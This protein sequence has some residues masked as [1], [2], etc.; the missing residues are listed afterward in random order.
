MESDIPLSLFDHKNLITIPDEAV[1]WQNYPNPFNPVTVI[2][3]QLAV[4]SRVELTVYNMRG[5]KVAK[6]VDANQ[7][8]GRHSIEWHA[9][10]LASGV[11]IYCLSTDYGF[12]QTK[13]LI[14]L[15]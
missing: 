10:N 1:L 7:S 8:A 14:L 13:K 9:G 5:Q 4:G 2:S 3:W 15:K 12:R 11:Y 6:L